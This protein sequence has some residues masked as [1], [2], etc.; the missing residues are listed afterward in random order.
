VDAER[1]A[2]PRSLPRS[3]GRYRILG[4]LGKG[5]MGVVYSGY[6]DMM[7]RS[8]A[9]KVM[10]ADLEEDPET[11]ARFYREAR[12]AGQL[13]HPNIITIYDM[14]E[15][16]GRL[17]IVM[18]L[19]EGE[20]LNKYLERPEAADVG[21][22]IDLMIQMCEGLAVAHSR[23]IFHRDVKPGNLLVRPNGELKI[24]DFGIAR[25]ASS[26]MT[27]SGLIVGTPDYMSPEQACGHE[28]DHRSDIFSAGAVFY[29]ML[30]GRKPFAAAG[31]TAVL[32]K[33]QNEDPLPIRETEGPEPLARLV[34]KAL[35]KNPGD[36]YQSC[37]DMVAELE[38]L[39]RDLELEARQWIGD[40]GRR[41]QSLQSMANQRR[42][43]IDALDVVPVPADLEARRADLLRARA[44]LTE[45]YPRGAVA[46]LLDEVEKVHTAA[47][48]DVDKWQRALKA[49][50][51]G[52]RAAAEGRMRE[53]VAH[54]ELALRIEPASKR[55]AAEADRCRRTI[56]EQRA[57]DDRA[58]ALLEEARRA[59]DAKQWQAAIIL[60][61]DALMLDGGAEEATA[62]K[63]KA[64]DAIEA[65]ARERRV[66][67]EQA[68]G[69]AET[70]RRSKRFK[71]AMLELERARG[72]S[73]NAAELHALEDRLRESIAQ[74]ERETQLTQEA[75]AAIA[76]AHQAFSRGQRDQ[77]IAGLRAFHASA[78]EATIAAEIS[79]LEA[80]A[81]RMAAA[82]QRA[83]EAAE[84]ANAA[85]AALAAGNPR[86]A[87]DLAARALAIDPGHL[88]AR[89]VSGLAGAEL[90]QQ[91]EKKAR[92]A[93]AAQQIEEAKQQAAR[94]KFQK[95]RALVSAA[96]DLNPAD[97]QH[98]HVLAWIQEEE[99]RAAAE[100]ERQRVAKQRA[101]AVAPI[102]ERARAAEAQRDYERASWTAEN[103]LAVDLE[104]G[105]A[106][107]ILR[108][109]K[110]QLAARPELADDTA[111]LTNGTGRL[112]DPDDTVSLTRPTGLWGRVTGLLRGWTQREGAAA[113]EKRQNEESQRVKTLPE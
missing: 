47:V 15:D 34:M 27:A 68:L 1:S 89:K 98:K 91:A 5:A 111:D 73:P 107:E 65:E 70:H 74:T 28:V 3:I 76:A 96:A 23:G 17:F 9:I 52:S 46:D 105:E 20:T 102:L 36:R 82:E 99:A 63:R 26:N 101:K 108:R 51:D 85:E 14:G 25:L 90:R 35:S 100:A 75:A 104:C 72:F 2:S 59:A 55:A 60:C 11:S 92:A 49:V 30:T 97:S 110:E 16:N 48:E 77:A 12:S 24:V 53:A 71:E 13:A 112:R 32:A 103:A 54:L 50:E 61:N 18:E 21:T 84:H 88:L 106:K 44:S 64:V 29:L 83:A 109:A 81:K 8:V 86:Q 41:L 113:R 94:G 38:N 69:R 80:E 19:L 43:L 39:K 66:E 62:L 56:A 78:P 4:R 7:E 6:D 40:C 87:V 22:K 57:V 95:A 93:R 67:C 33:V 45:P 31:L 10:M 42:T 79:R 58:N 37:G